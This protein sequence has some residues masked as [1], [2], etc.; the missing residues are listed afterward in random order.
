MTEKKK[1]GRGPKPK[2][3]NPLA[4]ADGSAYRR[5]MRVDTTRYRH[6]EEILDAMSTVDEYFVN[7]KQEDPLVLVVEALLATLPDDERAVVEM[8]LMARMSMHETARVLGY[9]NANGKEDHKMVKRRLEWALKKLRQTL[10]SPSFSVAIAGH[11]L[12]IEQPQVNITDTISKII[13]GLEKNMEDT[14]E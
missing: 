14:D 6:S 1:G 9:V 11:R 5:P 7:E 12:P 2:I 3:V 8:C 13:E 10:N 4:V